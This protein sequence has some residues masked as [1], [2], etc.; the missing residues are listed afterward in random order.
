M[1]DDYKYKSDKHQFRAKSRTIDEM[2]NDY[3]DE[4]KTL[5]DNKSEIIEKIN[6]IDQEINKLEQQKISNLDLH[7]CRQKNNLKKQKE[8]LQQQL[9]KIESNNSIVDYF[10]KC[11]DIIYDYY[12]LTNGILYGQETED[13]E[14][15]NSHIEISKELMELTKINKTKKVK[16]EV[17]K[18]KKEDDNDINYKSENDNSIMSFFTNND[19]DSNSKKLCKTSLQNEYLT[20]FDA[21]YASKTN[22]VSM[23]K[24]CEKCNVKMILLY[25]DAKIVCPI[26]GLSEI[27]II[28]TDMPLHKES[29]NEKPKYPYKR[30]GHC[31][32]KLNQLLCKK[33]VAIP[34][35]V[36]AKIYLEI[37][38][39]SIEKE[40]ISEE[41]IHKVLKKNKWVM[42]YDDIRYIHSK[43]TGN[44]PETITGDEYEEVLK[45][46]NMADDMY[47]KK[48]KPKDRNNFLK[49]TFVLNKIFLSIDRPDIAKHF[50][51][52]KSA[53]RTKNHDKVW[54]CICDET[55]WKYF[56][57]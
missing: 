26:C 22:K 10:Y 20:I 8:I 40:T 12:D 3:L 47:E 36:Y 6:L 35:E 38:K 33:T 57:S 49:Y 43:I 11:G 42:L 34:N 30:I 54:K 17:R 14:K 29:F 9:S 4:F 25:S 45:R 7:H 41:F 19:N 21:D 16:K 32:E 37:K 18:R 24:D 56:S 2:H 28:E 46:F 13:I 53:I 27:I 52:F 55:G 1:C 44:I 50:K 48:F 5:I 15:P 31:I 51:L 23:V 39:H